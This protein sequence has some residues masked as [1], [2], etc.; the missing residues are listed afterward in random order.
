MLK[1]RWP[2]WLRRGWRT[3][4][5]G[6]A[7]RS[8]GPRG[9]WAS[10]RVREL[11]PRIVPIAPTVLS[12]ARTLPLG[13]VTSAS[14]VSYTLTF[15]QPVHGVTPADFRL[16]ESG[17]VQA[18]TPVVLT[19]SNSAQL[20][21][22]YTVTVNGI[23]GSGDLRLDL[24]NDATITNDPGTPLASSFQGQTYTILQTYPSVL[25]INRTNPMSLTTGL[26]S[27]TFTV[28][29]SEP[30]TGVASNDFTLA[31]TGPVTAPLTQVTPVSGSVYQVT[32][33]GITGSGTL[34]LNLVDNG[35]IHDLAGNPLVQQ[36]APAA[37]Q[38]QATFHRLPTAL[39]GGGGPHRQRQ[40]RP[41][42]PQLCQQQCERV[43]G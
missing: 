24:I 39:R 10:L 2:Q 32:V 18:A 17:S 35:S 30:V 13:P 22:V 27:V 20:S 6:T 31:L 29:F 42:R 38:N 11:E 3:L 34:G 12:I 41:D 9:V 37:F 36:N 28:T 21:S 8:S 16:K 33:S 14:S 25:S 5:G 1:Q 15:S 26:S 40:A 7:R 43:A 23:H 19:P 4:A